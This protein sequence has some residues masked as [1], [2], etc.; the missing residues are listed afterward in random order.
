MPRI[1]PLLASCLLVAFIAGVTAWT[2]LA[3]TRNHVLS[4]GGVIVCTGISVVLGP[5]C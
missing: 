2:W 3:L 5:G 4:P 1:P